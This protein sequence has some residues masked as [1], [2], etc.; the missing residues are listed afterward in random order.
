MNSIVNTIMMYVI[1]MWRLNGFDTDAATIRT[2][3][4]DDI[5]YITEYIDSHTQDALK[6]EE[7]AKM[8]KMSYSNFAKSF[9]EIYGMSCKKYIEFVRLCKAEKMIRFTGYD[10]N[11]ISQETGFSD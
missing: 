8:C 1:R 11:Y 6:V 10:M 9:R 2:A 5:F 4:G 3:G 7:L